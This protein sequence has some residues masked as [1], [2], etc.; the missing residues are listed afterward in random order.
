MVTI[1]QKF[2]QLNPWLKSILWFFMGVIILAI[3]L[4]IIVSLFGDNYVA[5]RLKKQVRRSTNGVYTL[6]F[7]NVKVNAFTGSVT[8]ENMSLHA[9]K[10][11]FNPH[12]S[13]GKPSNT[14]YQATVDKLH[15]GGFNFFSTLFGH[16]LHI[17]KILIKKPDI[18]ITKNPH[19]VPRDT[20]RHFVSLDSTIFASISDQYKGLK[21]G[22]FEV[23][24]G[25]LASVQSRDTLLS[26]KKMN[27][28]LKNIQVDSASI[29]SGRVFITDDIAM[30]MHDLAMKT[31]NKLSTFKVGQLIISS[32]RKSATIDSLELIPRYPKFTFSQKNGERIDR[33]NLVIPK[34]KF[35]HVNFNAYVSS[36]RFYSR[37]AEIDNM[38]LQ[39]FNSK[40]PPPPSAK[41]KPLPNERLINLDQKIK[42]DSLMVEH[43]FISYAEYHRSASE[44]GKVT[45]KNLNGAFYHVTNYQSAIKKGKTIKMRAKAKVMGKGLLD[46]HASFPLDTH[47]SFQK[48]EGTLGSMLLTDFNPALEYI[49]FVKAERGKLNQLK[50]NFT[51][52]NDSS[53]GTIIMNYQNLKV[54]VLDK[55][56]LKEQGIFKNIDKP[57][58]KISHLPKNGVR[59]GKIKFHRIKEAGIF[60]YWW[61]SLLS[62]IKDAI[63]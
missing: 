18:T 50:F 51:A 8:F 16:K 25:R 15:I 53:N 63:K 28:T 39:D 58:T 17:G 62:G 12:F 33:I 14:L 11:A 56:A 9:D 32:H 23:C 24:G 21:I 59:S 31:S 13:S 38:Q 19:P 5:H 7:K 6:H 40:I 36:D 37:Y 26:V 3:L 61:R 27:L 29:D 57:I 1:T 22:T 54:S 44:A 49:A 41:P 34:I 52:N 42:I 60:H 2:R 47:N 48:V 43:S 4:A 46:V 20:S 45:F 10:A 55:K 30:E 35:Q